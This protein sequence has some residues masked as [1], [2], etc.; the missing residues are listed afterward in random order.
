MEYGD[1]LVVIKNYS[2]NVEARSS[3]LEYKRS[4]N[5]VPKLDLTK[6]KNPFEKVQTLNKKEN[7]SVKALKGQYQSQS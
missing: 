5:L 2:T 3:S 4:S 7:E 6:L 1:G